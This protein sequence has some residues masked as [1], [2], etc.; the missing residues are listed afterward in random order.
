MQKSIAHMMI[1]AA[2]L[3]DIYLLLLYDRIS[4]TGVLERLSSSR[5]RDAVRLRDLDLSLRGVSYPEPDD[6]RGRLSRCGDVLRDDLPLDADVL[7]DLPLD[8]DE[9]RDLILDGDGFR[10]RTGDDERDACREDGLD[11]ES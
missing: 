1:S 5:D 6:L 3:N 10:D 11:L 2:K 9:V 4:M 7:C 8:G